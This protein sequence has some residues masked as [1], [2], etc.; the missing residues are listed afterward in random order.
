MSVTIEVSGI[1]ATVEDMEW[2][3]DHEGLLEAI[4]LVAP[5]TATPDKGWRD[6]YAAETVIRLLGAGRVVRERDRPREDP[7]AVY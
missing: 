2:S 3:S 4:A 5:T 7:N 1:E 6:M